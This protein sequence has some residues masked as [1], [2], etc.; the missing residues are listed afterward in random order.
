ML[1]TDLLH[2]DLEDREWKTAQPIFTEGK[3]FDESERKQFC[4][5]INSLAN[6]FVACL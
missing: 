5:L 4:K 1:M 2:V 6:T 3:Y